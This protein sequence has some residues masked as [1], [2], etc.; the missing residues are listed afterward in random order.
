MC[1]Q[2]SDHMVTTCHSNQTST[3]RLLHSRRLCKGSQGKNRTDSAACNDFISILKK[4]DPPVCMTITALP[5]RRRSKVQ[6]A[7]SSVNRRKPCCAAPE[8]RRSR[9]LGRFLFWDIFAYYFPHS[10]STPSL[11]SS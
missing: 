1:M 11:H 6:W 7:A 9:F 8:C 3:T 10:S 4:Y 2:S 5:I